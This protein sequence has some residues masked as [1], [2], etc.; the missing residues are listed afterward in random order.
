MQEK[1]EAS[2]STQEYQELKDMI[3]S[4]GSRIDTILTSLRACQSRCHVDN[5]PASGWRGLG[6]ALLALVK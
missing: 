2:M 3:E 1:E 6:R 5:P 4:V